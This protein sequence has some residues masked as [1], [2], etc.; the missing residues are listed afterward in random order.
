MRHYNDRILQ[1][2]KAS[3]VPLIY[4]TTRITEKKKEKYADVMGHISTKLRMCLLKTTL[5]SVR[6][7]RGTSKGT[8]KPLSSVAFNLELFLLLITHQLNL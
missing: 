8:I 4:T 3:F 6:G 7:S 2:E 5:I 1:V